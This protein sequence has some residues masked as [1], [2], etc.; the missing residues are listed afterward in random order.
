MRTKAAALI[1]IHAALALALGLGSAVT[2][3]DLPAG[4]ATH[5]VVAGD[6][7]PH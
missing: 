3:T 6:V 1:G 2:A 5:R 7:G 4:S